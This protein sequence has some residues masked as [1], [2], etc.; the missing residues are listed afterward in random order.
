MQADLT[1]LI[2]SRISHDLFNPLGAISNGVELLGLVSPSPELDL[3]SDSVKSATA[4]LQM[5]RIAFGPAGSG[6]ISVRDWT[7]I[8]AGLAAG[9]RSKYTHAGTKPLPRNE[10]KVLALL[11]LCCDSSLPYGGEVSFTPRTGGGWAVRATGREVRFNANLW[12]CATGLSPRE[13]IEPAQVQFLLV[14]TAT[15]AIGRTLMITNTATTLDL[16]V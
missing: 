9:G 2:T 16:Q 1:A 5:L 8:L 7:G 4:R 12:A 15:T 11:A 14:P 13:P 10:A 3:I 6:E